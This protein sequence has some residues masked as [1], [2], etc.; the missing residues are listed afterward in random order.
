MPIYEYRC[1]ACEKRTTIL[2]RSFSAAVD[3]VCAHCGSRSLERLISRV[4]VIHSGQDLY[5]DYD[6][7]SWMDDRPGDD[8]L[9]DDEGESDDGGMSGG[10]DL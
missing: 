7:T 10:D 6:R 9:G 1:Q 2:V 4:A 5:E 8:D 3:P